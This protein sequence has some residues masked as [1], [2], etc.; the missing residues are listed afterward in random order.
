MRRVLHVPKLPW[1]LRSDYPFAHDAARDSHPSPGPALEASSF[2]WP[3]MALSRTTTIRPPYPARGASAGYG[4]PGPQCEG[5]LYALISSRHYLSHLAYKDYV[6]VVL[7]ACQDGD[8]SQLATHFSPKLVPVKDSRYLSV[9]NHRVCA[10]INVL[11][12]AIFC[13]TSK[14]TP[15]E[16]PESSNVLSRAGAP[17]SRLDFISSQRPRRGQPTEHR[18]ARNPSIFSGR[19]GMLR[20]GPSFTGPGWGERVAVYLVCLGQRDAATHSPF[21]VLHFV[22]NARAPSRKP[23][24]ATS[25]RTMEMKRVLAPH[26]PVFADVPRP[27]GIVVVRTLLSPLGEGIDEDRGVVMQIRCLVT[28]TGCMIWGC[29]FIEYHRPR[30]ELTNYA[31]RIAALRCRYV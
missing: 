7:V 8:G 30:L 4:S 14:R 27:P 23:G 20:P 29:C 19:A 26:T 2:L 3:S 31:L 15:V 16:Y 9:Y 28:S 13:V 17:P 6:S 21:T 1:R 22:S 24:C 10:R 12:H 11:Q 5:A 18:A 25:H